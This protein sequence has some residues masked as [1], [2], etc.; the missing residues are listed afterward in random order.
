VVGAVAE[1]VYSGAV[2]CSRNNIQDIST[3]KCFTFTSKCTKMRLAAAKGVERK[4]EEPQM[5]EVH[6]LTPL[7]RSAYPSTAWSRLQAGGQPGSQLASS[8]SQRTV[9][10][11][12]IVY[13]YTLRRCRDYTRSLTLPHSNSDGTSRH[14]RTDLGLDQRPINSKSIECLNFLGRDSS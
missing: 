2:T 12:I 1:Q 13:I 10:R 4:G 6:A 8:Y 5:P 7:K 14:M 9:N 11:P 3:L